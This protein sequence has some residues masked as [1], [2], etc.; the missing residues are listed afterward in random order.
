MKHASAIGWV[1]TFIFAA[2]WAVIFGLGLH[3]ALANVESAPLLAGLIGLV[4]VAMAGFL[5]S[6]SLK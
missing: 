2:F 4:V 5:V 1:L 3:L 6:L